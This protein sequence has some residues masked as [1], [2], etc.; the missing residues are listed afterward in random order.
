MNDLVLANQG[1]RLDQ[2]ED[3]GPGQ[4]FLADHAAGVQH[5]AERVPR[6]VSAGAARP[7]NEWVNPEGGKVTRR[8]G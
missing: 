5:G 6:L 3:F 7:K 4:R 8:R 1:R 2:A